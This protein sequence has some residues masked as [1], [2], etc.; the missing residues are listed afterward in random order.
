MSCGDCRCPE[1]SSI[2]HVAAT[3]ALIAVGFLTFG[4]AVGSIIGFLAG[5]LLPALACPRR[6]A[7]A[8]A[9]G[10]APPAREP[11]GVAAALPDVPHLPTSVLGEDFAAEARAQAAA[12]R[13][14][15]AAVALRPG[16]AG[17]AAQPEL[18]HALT[19]AGVSE[20]DFI[21]VK[22]NVAGAALWHE[23][24]VLLISSQPPHSFTGFTP[25]GDCYE[26]DLMPGGTSRP[27]PR[28]RVVL[29]AVVCR[30]IW[31]DNEYT[32]FVL[33]LSCTPSW[34]HGRRPL[35]V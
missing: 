32:D 21:A 8:G 18:A 25:D 28:S 1:G 35:P 10:P 23:R 5:R 16:V 34:L 9:Q 29:R 3:G 13:E 4:L 2:P 31:R 26:E 33:F 7:G 22:Y 19:A 11:T 27:G 15:R 12:V 6:S 30:L 17:P 20:G 14:R 24:C